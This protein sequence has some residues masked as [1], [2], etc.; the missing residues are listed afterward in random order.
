MNKTE[1]ISSE[2]EYDAALARISELMDALSGPQGQETDPNHPHRVELDSLVSQVERYEDEHYPIDP[3][4]AI[5]AIA[6]AID[7]TGKTPSEPL[8]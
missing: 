3:P 6:I 2:A 4:N 8:P 1:T 7:Q 5:E